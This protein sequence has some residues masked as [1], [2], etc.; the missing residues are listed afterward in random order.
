LGLIL[1]MLCAKLSSL[2]S[3]GCG[4]R[5]AGASVDIG[6]G[7]RRLRDCVAALAEPDCMVFLSR[8]IE[9]WS[10]GWTIFRSGCLPPTGSQ[11]YEVITRLSEPEMATDPN[12][13]GSGLPEFAVGLG[14]LGRGET[15]GKWTLSLPGS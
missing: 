9:L 13:G 4:A 5:L 3:Q 12:I 7:L 1:H 10:R 15:E 2:A 8:F 6:A 14:L 11:T